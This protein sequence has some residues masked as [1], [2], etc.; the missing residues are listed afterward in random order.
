MFGYWIF[1]IWLVQIEICSKYTD[2]EDLVW[3]KDCKYLNKK[4]YVDYK[5]KYSGYI[6]LIKTFDKI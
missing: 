6:G 5:L 3:K 1:K 4:L 2:S